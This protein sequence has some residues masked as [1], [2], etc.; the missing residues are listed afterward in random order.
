MSRRP[1]H[2]ISRF[3]C[4]SFQ[5]C[6]S[7]FRFCVSQDFVSHFLQTVFSSKLLRQRQYS[8]PRRDASWKYRFV[9][10]LSPFVSQSEEFRLRLSTLRKRQ[11]SFRIQLEE[12]LH[13]QE[14]ERI[15]SYYHPTLS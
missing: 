5:S 11:T 7:L 12:P 4:F 13:Q 14:R 9:V 15:S 2:R 1:Y 6:R 3:V 10:R 8:L